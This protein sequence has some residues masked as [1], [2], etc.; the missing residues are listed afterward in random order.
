MKWLVSKF[1]EAMLAYHW[2]WTNELP[3]GMYEKKED[4]TDFRKEKSA[5]S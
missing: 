2:L 5:D 1:H 4:K 3:R